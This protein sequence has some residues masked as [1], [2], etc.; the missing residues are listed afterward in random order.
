MKDYTVFAKNGVKSICSV[1]S[2]HPGAADR[3][4][5]PWIRAVRCN[6]HRPDADITPFCLFVLSSFHSRS[7]SFEL[8]VS[9]S[10]SRRST[11]VR[12]GQVVPV[13]QR[14]RSR[15][16]QAASFCRGYGL[17]AQQMKPLCITNARLV[18]QRAAGLSCSRCEVRCAKAAGLL[19]TEH[20]TVVYGSSVLCFLGCTPFSRV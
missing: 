5:D 13:G 7:L 9:A 17:A 20:R 4:S 19:G 18:A 6:I 1:M 11:A 12:T 2:L 10:R 15:G 16:R 14:W 3:L 8:T